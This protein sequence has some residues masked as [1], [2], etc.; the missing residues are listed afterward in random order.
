MDTEHGLGVENDRVISLREEESVW[1]GVNWTT[2]SS[3]LDTRWCACVVQAEMF[4]GHLDL[5]EKRFTGKDNGL[6]SHYQVDG[7]WGH[8][9]IC[10]HKKRRPRPRADPQGTLTFKGFAWGE[11]PARREQLEQYVAIWKSKQWRLLKKQRLSSSYR[12]AAVRWVLP[13][14]RQG[15]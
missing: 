5:E 9:L 7:N 15:C 12:S 6:R 13:P 4:K 1:G 14:Q 2:A 10:D 3:F 11:D 8:K